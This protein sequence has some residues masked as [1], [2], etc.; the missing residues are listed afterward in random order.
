MTAIIRKSMQA[1]PHVRVKHGFAASDASRRH[2]VFRQR[3]L[4][5]LN[6]LL[7]RLWAHMPSPP[8]PRQW[9]LMRLC[10]QMLAP[11][12]SL[13]WHWPRCGCADR[14][15]RGCLLTLTHQQ[16]SG[17]CQL[18]VEI[19]HFEF[20]AEE[21]SFQTFSSQTD[22]VI[23]PFNGREWWGSR[24]KTERKKTLALGGCGEL[25]GA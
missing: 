9:R 11:P 12:Q 24:G 15:W 18:Q 8:Q 22:S 1:G 14:C 19:V 6:V 10:S 2:Y 3:F 16:A 7:T 23:E 21:D 17:L 13:H 4:Q 20:L 25:R 5:S